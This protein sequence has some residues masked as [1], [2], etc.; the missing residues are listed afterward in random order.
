MKTKA[1]IDH[2]TKPDMRRGYGVS[3]LMTADLKRAL[4]RSAKKSGRSL[5]LEIAVRLE[6][7]F[8]DD[9]IE[10]MVKRWMGG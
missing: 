1:S 7:S 10:A 8:R 4:V 6:R 5:S 3:T 9:D 2:P